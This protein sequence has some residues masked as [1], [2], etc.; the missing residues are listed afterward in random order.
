MPLV[1]IDLVQGK[2]RAHRDAIG[3]VAYEAMLGTLNVPKDDRFQLI[4]ERPAENVVVDPLYQEVLERACP[5]NRVEGALRPKGLGGLSAGFIPQRYP[6]S[7]EHNDHLF[8][9]A[10]QSPPARVSE[11]RGSRQVS[12]P[13][14]GG[15]RGERRFERRSACDRENQRASNEAEKSADQ[16]RI[17]IGAERGA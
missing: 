5:S 17:V 2:P 15:E 14:S 12:G 13:G 9:P 16:K 4:S 1:R 8:V 7:L 3:E 6:R 11:N 10:G